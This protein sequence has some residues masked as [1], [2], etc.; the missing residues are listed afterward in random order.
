M[1][2]SCAWI[3][4]HPYHSPKILHINLWYFTKWIPPCINKVSSTWLCA[5]Q[6]HCSSPFFIL[7]IMQRPINSLTGKVLIT[8]LQSVGPV[9]AG[10]A[11][12]MMQ[13]IQAWSEMHMNKLNDH[14]IW[15]IVPLWRQIL[16]NL[17]TE[18]VCAYHFLSTLIYSH[19]VVDWVDWV[20]L[21]CSSLKARGGTPW[22][23]E[24]G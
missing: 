18:M 16:S 4:Q 17:M 6:A 20:G 2:K 21:F 22:L 5:F 19:F 23:L 24:L 1:F 15:C 7:K 8:R 12:K 14:K 13:I 11:N 10:H 9:P 3:R